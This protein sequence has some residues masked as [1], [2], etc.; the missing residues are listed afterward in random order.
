M[1]LTK[2]SKATSIKESTILHC[3]IAFIHSKDRDRTLIVQL[4]AINCH[5]TNAGRNTVSNLSIW[6]HKRQGLV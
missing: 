2:S 6:R 3:F 1:T 5:A 4:F